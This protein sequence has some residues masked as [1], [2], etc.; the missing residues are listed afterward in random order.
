M[1]TVRKILFAAVLASSCGISASAQTFAGFHQSNY[2]GVYGILSNP[3]SAAATRYKWDLNIFGVDAKAG[4]T[5]MKI[6]KQALF[7]PPDTFRRNQDYFLDT[8]ARRRQNAWEMA[9]IMMPSVMYSIDEKQ[10]ISFIW[11]IRS[12]SNGGNVPTEQVNFFGNNFPNPEYKNQSFAINHAAAATNIWHEFSL[13]Y[14]RVLRNAYG[15][16]WKGGITIKYLAG[17]AAGYG[18]VDNARFTLNTNRSG[19]VSSGVMR[20]A[21]TENIEHWNKPSLSNLKP[22]GNSGIGADIG[23]IYE[24]RPDN[25]GF[26]DYVG[27]HWNPASDDYQFRIGFS[28]TDIGRIGYSKAPTNTDLALASESID[29]YALLYKKNQSIKQYTRQLNS[30]FT[31]LPTDPHFKMSLPTMLHLTGD[32]NIND[33]FFVAAN[34]DLS[35]NAGPNNIYKTYGMT[36]F[37]ITPRYE[38]EYFGAYMPFV[39]NHNGQADLGAGFRLGP[40]IFGSYSLF[41]NLFRHNLDHADA[42]VALRFIP[43]GKNDPNGGG[44]FHMRKRQLRCPAN[45]N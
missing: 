4:N 3:A 13:S 5:Y 45:S 11:R 32:Y 37:M 33:K 25:D 18:S 40:L 38:K 16:I 2:A 10:T 8:A 22:N 23:L 30:L 35:L 9:E 20:Y 43:F 21:Y 44:I 41:T 24:Y 39:L 1:T 34:L 15:G 29:P 12:S 17:V 28:I 36:Q 7:H 6:T 26:G 14:A 27:D 31:P 42:Y 19:S